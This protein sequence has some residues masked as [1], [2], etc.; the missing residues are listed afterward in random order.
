[1]LVEE[2]MSVREQKGR[3]KGK[4]RRAKGDGESSPAVLRSFDAPPLQ[5]AFP[6]AFFGRRFK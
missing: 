4:E 3:K 5:N 6:S 1:M 2:E